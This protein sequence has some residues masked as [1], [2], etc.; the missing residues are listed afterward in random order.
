MTSFNSSLNGLLLRM[1]RDH[2]Y[3]IIYQVITVAQGADTKPGKPAPTKARRPSE[4]APGEGRV[5]AAQELLSILHS[6]KERPIAKE[7]VD[8]MMQFTNAAVPWCLHNEPEKK[9]SRSDYQVTKGAALLAIVNVKIPPPSVVPPVDLT[10]RYKGLATIQR[11]RSSYKILGGIHRPK[12]MVCVDSSAQHH[13]ELVRHP[14]RAM[15]Q[16]DWQVQRR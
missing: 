13:F 6:D 7:A 5:P 14:V 1:A 10:K 16:A 15:S 3:H 9:N 8:R 2:P 11:Y 4:I 12:R